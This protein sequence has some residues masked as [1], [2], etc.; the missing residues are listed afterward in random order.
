MVDAGSAS[1]RG[2]S[3]L[4]RGAHSRNDAHGRKEGLI[5]AHAGS[6]VGEFR[7]LRRMRA[8]PRSRGEH[9][10]TAKNLLEL[11]GSSPL[12]RGAHVFTAGFSPLF[13]LIP[14]HAG[15]TP[16]RHTQKQQNRA[17]PRSRGEHVVRLVFTTGVWGSSPLTRG[18]PCGGWV[19]F[20]RGGLIPA[21][22]GSTLTSSKFLL[23]YSAHPRSR[24]E[25]RVG[26]WV[27]KWPS[28]SSPLT[29]GAL[30]STPAVLGLPRLIPA[31]AGSTPGINTSSSGVWAHPRS[32]GEHSIIFG[33]HPAA[34]GSSPL[35]RG[36]L[37][38]GHQPGHQYGLIPAHAGS[39]S[40]GLVLRLILWAHPR[41]RGEHSASAVASDP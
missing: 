21:H 30:P 1:C 4:T 20:C 9:P 40:V 8:H 6:T 31:H 37:Q 33:A 7:A 11:W 32:R 36:A 26:I 23:A 13:G 41:S 12:T 14:A 16:H 22:A 25:H 19:V 17:H 38:L 18:A 15:S 2:S 27:W 34:W 35:T 10:E 5:P 29:R 3:P 39:T 24:G 28:G